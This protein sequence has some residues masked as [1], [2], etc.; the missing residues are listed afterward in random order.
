[1]PGPVTRSESPV[2]TFGNVFFD[3]AVTWPAPLPY[4]NFDFENGGLVADARTEDIFDPRLEPGLSPALS[5]GLEAADVAYLVVIDNDGTKALAD[6]LIDVARV[7][8]ARSQVAQ[9]PLEHAHVR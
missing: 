6:D 7:E 1:M 5:S 3:L 8:A 4:L 9:Q 2:R